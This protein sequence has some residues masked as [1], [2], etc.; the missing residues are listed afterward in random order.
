MT[1]IVLLVLA[2]LPLF[3]DGPDVTGRAIP[4]AGLNQTIHQYRSVAWA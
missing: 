4:P 2:A 1:V 3:G